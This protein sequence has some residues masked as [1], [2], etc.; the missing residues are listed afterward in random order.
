MP[1]LAVRRHL[2]CVLAAPALA[3]TV[4]AAGACEDEA[5]APSAEPSA[6]A[7]PLADVDTRGVAVAREEFCSRIAPAAV[8]DALGGPATATDSYANGERARLADGVRDVA[9]EFGCTWS[10][11]DGGV[12]RAWV[13]A[14]PVTRR[15][16]G[17]LGRYAVRENGCA[18]VPDAPPFGA[19]T[20]G[21]RC[22][23]D[24][25]VETAFHGLVGDAW[26]SCS[27]VVSGP[28]D[29]LVERAGRWCVTVL[30]AAAA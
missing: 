25:A 1:V 10:A 11:A 22:E 17:E 29:E 8:E 6:S 13:L 23:A 30:Q 26:L 5:P 19:R 12:V 18:A 15:Q 16:A 7:T 4:L 21:V 2:G 9:H 3:L 14:P 20:V 24:G 28:D 27:V